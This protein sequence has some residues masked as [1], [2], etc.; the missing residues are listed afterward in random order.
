VPNVE[1]IR[2]Y[3]LDA[4]PEAW[5]P[6]Y[7][8][9]AGA[10]PLD[11]L[12][13]KGVLYVQGEFDVTE[14]GPIELEF[15]S[16]QGLSVWVDAEPFEAQGKIAGEFAAGKHKITLRIDRAA[17]TAAELKL[18]LVKPEGSSAQFQPVVGP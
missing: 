12:S 13:E 18:V 10:L 5:T 11:E 16:P 1:Q 14:A 3:V 7:S 2:A 8:K 9:V 15:D 6:I 17:R 4:K